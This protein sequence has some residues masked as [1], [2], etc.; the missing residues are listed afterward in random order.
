MGRKG[1]P[2]PKPGDREYQKLYMAHEIRTW[3][4]QSGAVPAITWKHKTPVFRLRAPSLIGV[5]GIALMSAV[6]RSGSTAI[7]SACGLPY[8][9]NR[10]PAAGKNHY[11]QRCGEN[12]KAAKRL[13]ARNQRES[14]RAMNQ[15]GSPEGSSDGCPPG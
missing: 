2:L 8:T 15:F 5:I 10:K 14:R 3:L 6:L 9:P 13:W 12:K 7:C 11:C 4:L 1:A